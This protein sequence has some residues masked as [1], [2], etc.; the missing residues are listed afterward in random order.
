MY[1]EHWAFPC[2]GALTGYSFSETVLTD[3]PH[4]QTLSIPT[5][6]S[7]T[8]LKRPCK[9]RNSQRRVITAP[10]R[11]NTNN[12]LEVCQPLTEG[13]CFCYIYRTLKDFYKEKKMHHK[14]RIHF[15]LK[16]CELIPT[17]ESICVSC[18]NFIES[19][20]K[21]TKEKGSILILLTS[22]TNFTHHRLRLKEKLLRVHVLHLILRGQ[23]FKVCNDAFNTTF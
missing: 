23:M 10:R 3:G 14:V 11:T 22:L 4:S 16:G 6:L 20:N 13:R 1:C 9:T 12:D 18:V 21:T 5:L 17:G 15:V 7:H 2:S 8:L 19:C